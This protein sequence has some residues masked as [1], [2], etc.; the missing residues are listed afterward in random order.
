MLPEFSV[1][2]TVLDWMWDRFRDEGNSD[3]SRRWGPDVFNVEC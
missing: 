3:E 2:F 1:L